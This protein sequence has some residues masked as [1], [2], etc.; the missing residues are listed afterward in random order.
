MA[1]VRLSITGENQLTAINLQEAWVQD[2]GKR[3]ARLRFVA[4]D[5]K[6][7]TC[8]AFLVAPQLLLTN[9]H[10]IAGDTELESALVDFDYDSAIA[11]TLFTRLKTLVA[12]DYDLDYSIVELL[13]TVDRTPLSLDEAAAIA[14]QD[15]LIIQHPGGQPKQVSV[16]DCK[17][18]L[19]QVKG[20]GDVQSD[21]E[22]LCDTQ[23]GS[24]GSPVIDRQHRLVV[25]LHHLGFEEDNNNLHNRAVH[26]GM[27]LDDLDEA[28]RARI[29]GENSD[30]ENA[31]EDQ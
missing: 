14:D 6:I 27:I 29:T 2:I 3:I 8:T 1:P 19:Q 25:G 13:D 18:G 10:C 15:L 24:S 20:R 11:E 21:F 16:Q 28:L 4:D 9:Q 17:V 7:Y 22:H 26:I 5:R 23:T 31:D 12:N 30:N